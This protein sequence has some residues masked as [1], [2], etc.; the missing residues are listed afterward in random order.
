MT[1][2]QAFGRSK[3]NHSDSSC[4]EGTAIKVMTVPPVLPL[5][6][7]A[8]GLSRWGQAEDSGS[9]RGRARRAHMGGCGGTV[10][11]AQPCTRVSPASHPRAAHGGGTSPF[12]CCR[13][14]G[15]VR[16]GQTALV[17]TSASAPI[18]AHVC[19]CWCAHNHG[20]GVFLLPITFLHLRALLGC[21]V[22]QLLL[23]GHTF[24]FRLTKINSPQESP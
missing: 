20:G 21:S 1:L 19:T 17:C 14:G 9:G 7:R 12:P 4:K 13:H 22:L 8:R 24:G 16:S 10:L 5:S 15:G 6:P 23:K 2:P 18:P 3:S 11:L